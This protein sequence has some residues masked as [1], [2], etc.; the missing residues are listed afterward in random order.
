M[1]LLQRIYKDHTPGC[2]RIKGR[3]RDAVRS[4]GEPVSLNRGGTLSLGFDLCVAALG[5]AGNVYICGFLFVRLS[6]L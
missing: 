4:G 6:V 1:L 3:P 2:T 5:S